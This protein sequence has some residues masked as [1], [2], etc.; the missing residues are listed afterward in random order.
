MKYLW[1]DDSLRMIVDIR[2][3]KSVATVKDGLTY[4]LQVLHT[5]GGVSSFGPAEFKVVESAYKALR[6]RLDAFEEKRFFFGGCGTVRL[7]DIKTVSYG[8]ERPDPL[9][10]GE[11]QYI[12]VVTTF[13]GQKLRVTSTDDK[14]HCE[15]VFKKLNELL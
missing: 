5:E 3:I 8:V 14:E 4:Y 11:K 6:G 7:T 10:G 12:L 13:D 1:S 2:D 9:C 15:R